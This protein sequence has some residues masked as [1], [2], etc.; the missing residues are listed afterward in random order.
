METSLVQV[1]GGVTSAFERKGFEPSSSSS[2][3]CTVEPL[4]VGLSK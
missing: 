3:S 4:V 2:S 1:E